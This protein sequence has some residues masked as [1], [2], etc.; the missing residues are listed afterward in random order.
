[1]SGTGEGV[2]W[3]SGGVPGIG[4]SLPGIGGW[5]SV[6]SGSVSRILSGGVSVCVSWT[7]R[8]FH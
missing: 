8:M 3:I 2:S 6:I 4:G 7:W 1:M 5:V